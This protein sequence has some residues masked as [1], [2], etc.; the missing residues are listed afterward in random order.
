MLEIQPAAIRIQR[1]LREAEEADDRALLAKIQLMESMVRARLVNDVN[2]MTGQAALL[3]LN[4][5]NQSQ[6]DARNDLGRVHSAMIEVAF[7][8]DASVDEN[9]CPPLPTRRKT[10]SL[11]DD[12]IAA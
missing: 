3:R 12:R 2:A 9:D 8:V 4:R 10:G 1:Q 11:E 7:Q 6:L 5:A